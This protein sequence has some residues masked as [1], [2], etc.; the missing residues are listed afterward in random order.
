[1]FFDDHNPPHF[2][3]RYGDKKGIFEIRTLNFIDGDLPI[4]VRNLVTEWA[5]MHRDEL[6][7]DWTLAQSGKMPNKIAPLV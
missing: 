1:M 7:E 4:K 3:A 2:H 5:D 6:L